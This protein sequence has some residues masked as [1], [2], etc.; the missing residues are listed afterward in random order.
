T[1]TRT[2]SGNCSAAHTLTH[3]DAPVESIVAARKDEQLDPI[4][5]ADDAPVNGRLASLRQ[6]PAVS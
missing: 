1:V 2:Q 3:V 4:G 5:G 6:P